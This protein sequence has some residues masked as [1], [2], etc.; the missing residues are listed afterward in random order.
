MLLPSYCTTG[1][2]KHC[3]LRKDKNGPSSKANLLHWDKRSKKYC[4]EGVCDSN[5]GEVSEKSS[6]IAVL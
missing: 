1:E 6:D 2:Q 5:R 3:R 4:K